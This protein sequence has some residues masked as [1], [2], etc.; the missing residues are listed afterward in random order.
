M[1]CPN[2]NSQI[3]AEDA[4]LST[5]VARC[6]A[7]QEVFRF[8]GQLKP[9]SQST[10]EARREQCPQNTVVELAQDGTM[11]RISIPSTSSSAL[12]LILPCVLGA[13]ILLARMVSL[14]WSQMDWGF[15][16]VLCCPLAGLLFMCYVALAASLNTTVLELRD[17]LLLLQHV[18]MPWLGDRCFETKNIKRIEF[19]Q[20]SGWARG[21]VVHKFYVMAVDRHGR[22]F[23]L[24]QMTTPGPARF[25]AEQLHEWLAADRLPS[26]EP[27]GVQPS[28]A[29][30]RS[31]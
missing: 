23:P 7:C 22:Q 6:R 8:E 20:E 11:K 28:E 18:P 26:P 30:Q 31:R 9:P 14:V 2:C 15:F 5:L 12:P 27:T 24:V 16:T 4:N 19:H 13:L 17:S 21:V 3:L 29:I 1:Y 10:L 25:I